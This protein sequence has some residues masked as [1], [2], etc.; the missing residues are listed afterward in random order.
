MNNVNDLSDVE[1]RSF[2]SVS[3]DPRAV[4]ELDLFYRTITKLEKHTAILQRLN[5]S[6]EE[7]KEAQSELLDCQQI[8]DGKLN[9]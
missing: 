8:I 3:F 4:R 7:T 2:V 1:D 6:V 5:A 9:S